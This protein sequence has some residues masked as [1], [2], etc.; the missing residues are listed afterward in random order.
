MAKAKAVKKI[1]ETVPMD[2][3]VKAN[4]NGLVA[5]APVV[6]AKEAPKAAKKAVSIRTD[7]RATVIPDLHDEIRKLAYLLSERR[8]FAPGHET[9]DWLMAEH[10]VR[11]RYHQPTA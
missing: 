11:E 5:T 8:G 2:E 10:E 4:G 1:V 7:A 3:P 9:E 6:A